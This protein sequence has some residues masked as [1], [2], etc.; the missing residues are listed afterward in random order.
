MESLLSTHDST[1]CRE[2]LYSTHNSTPST[3][4]IRTPFRK[5][6]YASH[7]I[8]TTHAWSVCENIIIKIH[9]GGV[10][11]HLLIVPLVFIHLLIVLLAGSVCI[12]LHTQPDCNSTRQT[13][14]GH[15]LKHPPPT[16][17]QEHSGQDHLHQ[18]SCC[19]GCA[20][21]L[22]SHAGRMMSKQ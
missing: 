12:Y 18:H 13:A 22:W 14:C 16:F 15:P 2:S 1:P 8:I 21:L 11:I 4:H 5:S 3:L 19:A 17:H 7:V 20:S 6:L 9:S 10:F